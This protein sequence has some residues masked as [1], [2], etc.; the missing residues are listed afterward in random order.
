M[1]RFF[2]LLFAGF[3]GLAIGIAVSGY[4]GSNNEP[5]S[6]AEVEYIMDCSLLQRTQNCLENVDK[7]RQLGI[8]VSP[9]I[10]VQDSVTH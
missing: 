5:L 7:L 1:K 10:P 3:A 2:D 8:A 6:E 4:S 9:L